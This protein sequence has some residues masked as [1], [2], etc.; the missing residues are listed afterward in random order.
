MKKNCWEVKGCERC[1]T[2]L[3]DES[4]PVC[5]ESKLHGVHGGVNGGRACWAIPHSKCGGSTQGSFGCKFANCMACDFYKMVKEEEQG[6]FQL[7][8]TILSKLSPIL[9]KAGK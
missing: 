2:I 5:K 6:G 4:C 8:A 1:T 7:S 9:S 3:A